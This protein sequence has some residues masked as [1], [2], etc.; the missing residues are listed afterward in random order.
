MKAIINGITMKG[1]PA[2]IVD[3]QKLTSTSDVGEFGF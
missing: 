2:E 3:N 1:T